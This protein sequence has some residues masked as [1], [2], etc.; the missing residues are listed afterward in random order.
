MEPYLV[1]LGRRIR[2]LRKAGSLSQ[3]QLAVR[4]EVTPKYISQVETGGANP[5]VLI[6]RAIAESGLNT[7]LS[8]LF[9]FDISGDESNVLREEVLA[10]LNSVS[11][12]QR[13]KALAVLRTLCSDEP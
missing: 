4:A 9:N 3:E 7:P 8:G 11:R 1:A 12:D 10:L 5:S 2:E 6:L 13:L